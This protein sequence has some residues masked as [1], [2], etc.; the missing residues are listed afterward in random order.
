MGRA[1]DRRVGRLWDE[2]LGAGDAGLSVLSGAVAEP[3]SGWAGILSGGD[4]QLME[5]MRDAFTY[6]PRTAEGRRNLG[7]IGDATEAVMNYQPLL[8]DQTIGEE[9]AG[10]TDYWNER[11]IP[12]LQRRLATRQ[13]LP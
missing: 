2:I 3:V 1:T 4:T 9:L 11:S 5:H 6:E 12:A 8:R 10:M 7:Y 13:A